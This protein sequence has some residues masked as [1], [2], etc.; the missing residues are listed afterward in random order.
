[1]YYFALL[2]TNFSD[3][4]AVSKKQDGN[5]IHPL[6][7]LLGKSHSASRAAAKHIGITNRKIELN[8]SVG[9]LTLEITADQQR[10]KDLKG[11]KL[12]RICRQIE[13][14]C[15]RENCDA[16]VLPKNRP[17]TDKL[18]EYIQRVEIADCGDYSDIAKGFLRIMLYDT[19]S[20]CLERMGIKMAELLII[21]G[22]VTSER[23]IANI[24]SILARLVKFA[25]IYKGRV[26]D[27]D[28]ISA[29]TGM[30]AMLSSSL[31]KAAKEAD[32]VV[33]LGGIGDAART[34]KFK[35]SA[36]IFNFSQDILNDMNTECTVIN[37]IKAGLPVRFYSSEAKGFFKHFDVQAI[38]RLSL[39]Y[40][41]N[42]IRIPSNFSNIESVS[43][44]NRI[45]K[46]EGFEIA[47][48]YGRHGILKDV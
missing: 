33:D 19:A 44:F 22:S 14:T 15:I 7:R 12:K 5:L 25:V 29:E 17:D 9:V 6:S 38:A 41:A 32:L 27:I 45:F 1:M 30:P 31:E 37:G 34:L 40:C 47:G 42:S 43:Q 11:E 10:F 18:R 21:A 2:V 28:E 4:G 26:E 46:S 35:K 13:D 3:A 39:Q 23:E 8:S 20:R 36:V 48:Y 16:L 24:A